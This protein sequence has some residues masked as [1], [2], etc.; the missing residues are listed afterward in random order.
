[1]QLYSQR[2][3]H[4]RHVGK[5]EKVCI[6]S[7]YKKC[8]WIIKIQFTFGQILGTFRLP[9]TLRSRLSVRHDREAIGRPN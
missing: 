1:M 4:R 6:T 3:L 5:N 2:K 9:V 8:C 7:L